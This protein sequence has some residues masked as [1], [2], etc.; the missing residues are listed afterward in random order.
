MK[1]MITR[2]FVGVVRRKSYALGVFFTQDPAGGD[3]D[4]KALFQEPE[5]GTEAVQE[6]MCDMQCDEMVCSTM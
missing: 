1:V 4:S 5:P 3:E 2:S 6:A